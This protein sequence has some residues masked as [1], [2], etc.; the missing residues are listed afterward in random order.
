MNIK[1]FNIFN[2]LLQVFGVSI[3]ELKLIFADVG[4]IIFFL[5]VCLV[6]PVLYSL[7]YN[8]ELPR[9][10]KVVVVDDDRSADTR[11]FVRMLD[12]T[13]EV[14]VV[15][16]AASM[17]EARR[18][19]NDHEC[20]SIVHFPA[21]FSASVERLGEQAHVN[22]YCDMSVMM[23]YR[24]T[25]IAVN[26]VQQEMNAHIQAATV[27]AIPMN[28]GGTT[29]DNKQVPLGNTAMGLASAVLPCILVLVLQQS[30]ILG[31]GML[32]GGS[33]DRRRR[34]GGIDPE[35]LNCSALVTVLGRTVAYLLVYVVPTFYTLLLVPKFFAFPQNGNPFEIIMM[36][37]PYLIACALFAQT[38]KVLIKGREATFITLVFTSVGFVFLSG[39]SWPRYQMSELWQAVGNM[40]P[41]TWA[42]SSYIQMQSNGASL[43]DQGPTHVMLWLLCGIYLVTATFA[44]Y[45]IARRQNT[46]ESPSPLKGERL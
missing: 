34:N 27:S 21:D 13:Q 15:G 9:D 11:E 29:L 23:R 39:I 46:G 33:R 5:V 41:S 37:L 12:A 45:Y 38:L 8:T 14:A 6:Y 32:H 10:V 24:Q 4:V 28:V 18:L 1:K 36:S 26:A 3:R 2:W 17:Q 19:V 7:I 31:V 25:L 40:I 42:A 30:M 44:E 35:Q 20:Y 43:F 16:Y 22:V